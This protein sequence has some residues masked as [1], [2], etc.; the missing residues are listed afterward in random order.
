MFAPIL[1]AGPSFLPAWQAFCEE[2]RDAPEPPLY[3]VL[4]D[5]SRHILE[6]LETGNLDGMDDIFDVIEI[7]HVDGDA[8][9]KEAATIGLLEGLQNN[10]SHIEP[11]PL[12]VR[13]WLRPVSR[14][15]WDKLNRF[16]E[17]DV[18]ALRYDE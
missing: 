13:S 11:S 16:W 5:L 2:W 10:L 14:T 6:R 9:V 12:I 15:W 8:Y 3:V 1:E 4:G 18:H 7:W 17:G